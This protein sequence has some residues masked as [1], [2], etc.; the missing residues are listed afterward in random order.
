MVLTDD[1][2]EKREGVLRPV[3]ASETEEANHKKSYQSTHQVLSVNSSS[4]L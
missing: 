3:G 1:L 4:V 2:A